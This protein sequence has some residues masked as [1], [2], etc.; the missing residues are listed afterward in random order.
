MLGGGGRVEG[1]GRERV[2]VVVIAYGL[3]LMR[4]GRLCVVQYRQDGAYYY[5]SL[6]F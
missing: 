3:T 1:R 2:I 6:L 5:I 4:V